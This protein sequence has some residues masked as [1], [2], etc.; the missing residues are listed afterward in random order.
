MITIIG[1]LMMA[2]FSSGDFAGAVVPHEGQDLTRDL[3]AG[4][5]HSVI[6]D[7]GSVPEGESDTTKKSWRLYPSPGPSSHDGASP[8][9]LTVQLRTQS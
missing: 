3:T 6:S 8:P 5:A 9:P 2:L 7:Y 4:S 1:T